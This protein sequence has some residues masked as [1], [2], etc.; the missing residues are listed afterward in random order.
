MVSHQF[1]PESEVSDEEEI[2]LPPDLNDDALAVL[3][4][5]DR[6]FLL[7]RAEEVL[8]AAAQ[9]NPDE[10]LTFAEFFTPPRIAKESHRYGFCCVASRDRVNGWEAV[11]IEGNADFWKVHTV[12]NPNF[13]VYSPPCTYLS[14]LQQ[15]TP[16]HKR[17]DPEAY[18]KGVREALDCIALCVAGMLWQIDHGKYYIFESSDSSR[19][20]TIE[21]L[22]EILENFGWQIPVPGCSVGSQDK[23][24]HRPF[25][26]K[27]RFC[28]NSPMLAHVLAQLHCTNSGGPDDHQHQPVEG[29]SG[30]QSRS[31]QS[32]VYPVK[33]CRKIVEGMSLQVDADR[34]EAG[35]LA[36]GDEDPLQRPGATGVDAAIRRFHTNLGHPSIPDMI[37][38]LKDAGATAPVLERVRAFQCDHCDSRTQPKI[39]RGVAPPKTVAPLRYAGMDVKHLRGWQE[40]QRIRAVNIVCETS[41][42]QQMTPFFENETSEVL[43]RIYRSSWSRPYGR[44][45]WLK[46]D[47]GRTNLGDVLQKSLERDQTQLLD[48]PGQAHE[49]MGRTEVHGKYFEVMFEKVLDDVRPSTK[50][51][52]MECIDQTVEAKNTLL[53]RNGHSPYQIALGRNPEVPGDLLQDEPDVIANS[54]ILH[55]DAAAFTARVRLSAQKAVIEF[56][57]KIAARKALDQRPRPLRSFEIGDEVAVWRRGK[58]VP[59]KQQ[60]AMWRGPG[61]ILGAVRGNYWISMPGSVIKASSEQLR[62]RTNEEREGDR[63][64]L[65][66]LRS[67]AANLR[68]RGPA[69]QCFED[70]TEE[71]FPPGERDSV[72]VNVDPP[73][74]APMPE[75][76][77]PGVSSSPGATSSNQHQETDHA[78]A[79]VDPDDEPPPL[80]PPE[81]EDFDDHR[82]PTVQPPDD[83]PP[84]KVRRG[85]PP[86]AKNKPKA[87]AEDGQRIG[88]QTFPASLPQPPREVP[89][90]DGDP[91]ETFVGI[92]VGAGPDDEINEGCLLAGGRRELDVK[93]QKWLCPTGLRK[94]RDGVLKEFN[95]LAKDK[96]AIRVLSLEESR[97]VDPGRIVPSRTVL[98][99]KIEDGE[100]IVKARLT[101]RGDKD[102]DL[103]SLVREGKTTSPTIST[104]GKVTAKQTIASM[105]FVMQLGDVTGAFLESDEL[106]RKKGKIYLSQPRGGIPGLE[107]GQLLEVI[108][109]IYGLNDAPQLWYGKSTT[110]LEGL[111]WTRSRLDSCL[112]FL[113]DQQ[114]RLIGVMACHV[115]DI[116]CGGRGALFDES[117]KKLRATFP[118][119]KWK[120][121]EGEFCGS[122]LRQDPE[123]FDIHISQ[124][125]YALEQLP[126]V[127]VRPR[128]AP[129]EPATPAEIAS[130]RKTCGAGQWLCKESR[131]DLAVQTSLAQQSFPQPTVG[132]CRDANSMVRRAR[133]F[134][135]LEWVIKSV[136]IDDLRIV[137]HSD[138]AFQ[139][140]KGGA[141]Q[142]GYVVGLTTDALRQGETAPWWPISW[143]SHRMK[144]VV[145]STLA[146]ETQSLL[147][148]LPDFDIRYRSKWLGKLGLQCV[149]DCKSLFDHLTSI[150]V[151]TTVA[152]KRCAFDIIIAR[153]C[154]RRCQGTIRWAPTDRQLAD[155]LTK[156]KAE[157]CD[158]LR[159]CMRSLTYQLANE[160]KVLDEAARER[161][162]RKLMGKKAAAQSQAG[163]NPTQNEPLSAALDSK[164]ITVCSS[165]L[166]FGG[167]P[168]SNGEL[169]GDRHRASCSQLSRESRCRPHEQPQ[170]LQDP[171]DGRY[172]AH[173][174]V[175]WQRVEGDGD[176]DQVD[177]EGSSD[178]WSSHCRQGSVHPRGSLG[179][180]RQVAERVRGRSSTRRQREVV[181]ALPREALQH[182]H[183]QPEGEGR[184]S[185]DASALHPS[186]PAV[187][188][189]DGEHHR[190]CGVSPR[191]LSRVEPEVP[192]SDG[193]GFRCSRRD[194]A[195]H[196]GSGAI[197]RARVCRGRRRF[198]DHLLAR[199]KGQRRRTEVA[200][201]PQEQ[202]C[203]EAGLSRAASERSVAIPPAT[204]R[205]SAESW[206]LCVTGSEHGPFMLCSAVNSTQNECK[207]IHFKWRAMISGWCSTSTRLEPH[208]SQAL[209]QALS[210]SNQELRSEQRTQ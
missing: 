163:V 123:T 192:D 140:A 109:P 2:A 176:L 82:V 32:Q 86:G 125:K 201:G 85:R 102:P 194:P 204:E 111:G 57:N 18:E 17:K 56:S 151:P 159:A 103:L 89:L 38:I 170:Q 158:L 182:F 181:D 13:V 61:I 148:A 47:S 49:Q 54:A 52:W 94:I 93:D 3:S 133:Q 115:D 4:D 79:G 202:L 90:D 88:S 6:R 126:K 108:K 190:G 45:R 5:K 124:S 209:S 205:P 161:E 107:P 139:N 16:M 83:E 24:S 152:D 78:P 173:Q 175:P 143:K 92:I 15:C 9:R 138:A 150:G 37:R 65:S 154:L 60:Y 145:G 55:D 63:L 164:D 44:L 169:Q 197:P 80:L 117:I 184:C 81:P 36:L 46:V 98:T 149:I 11:S 87:K 23:I 62:H 67:A 200:A 144:R 40:G 147:D 186:G 22:M 189:G 10:D 178:G 71:E 25:G 91:A 12:M 1:G 137:Q 160:S 203:L 131:P 106:M 96:K 114:Q 162:R 183:D 34:I 95:M 104:N 185:G 128:A 19:T 39:S 157:P 64:V 172:A 188:P 208:L 110:T 33:L 122:S 180:V 48:V 166:V 135:D 141:S 41:A 156:D 196:V 129:E 153:Q 50:E 199:L 70:I 198:R 14:R 207:S 66:E 74:P 8:A 68:K 100:E 51:E 193:P 191:G 42:L 99:S 134:H 43:R 72:E 73:P 119:R 146:A 77:P 136:P 53:R 130:M 27:W 132:E 105:K 179:E 168:C 30:G 195:R 21:E 142:A 29:T 28:T 69:Q 155:A 121:G 7:N 101:A 127:V 177:A 206:E 187:H 120:I 76:E 165:L 58:G 113:R 97:R 35:V 59:G 210:Q 171:P 31:V 26:K 118:F 112:M 167:P 84:I 20:W 174:G 116:L 75:P